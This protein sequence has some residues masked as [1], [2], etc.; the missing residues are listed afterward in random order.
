M[1]VWFVLGK[2]HWGGYLSYGRGHLAPEGRMRIPWGGYRGDVQTLVGAACPLGW[3][4]GA[5]QPLQS[6]HRGT[7]SLWEGCL[8]LEKWFG[9]MPGPGGDAWP[10][11]GLWRNVWIKKGSNVGLPSLGERLWAHTQPLGCF[12][13]GC[14]SLGAAPGGRYGRRVLIAGGYSGRMPCFWGPHPQGIAR[15]EL[16]TLEG[17]LK[18]DTHPP[19]GWLCGDALL[20][21]FAMGGSPSFG[22][23]CGEC[24][25][26]GVTVWGAH[27]CRAP[28]GCSAHA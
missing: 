6:G 26:P 2:R 19:W 4:W 18:G 24:P 8:S 14:P 3:L 13:W 7:S 25:P 20:V 23:R 11:R 1:G 28:G 10:F 12:W 22:V 21:V 17:C 16:P 15:G 27:P 5:A 9:E